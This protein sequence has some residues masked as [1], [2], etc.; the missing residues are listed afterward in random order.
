M[1]VRHP[2]VRRALEN[3]G[4][5]YLYLYSYDP[6]W[7]RHVDEFDQLVG[8]VDRACRDE[9]VPPDARERIVARMV[10]RV[11]PDARTWEERAREVVAIANFPLDPRALPDELRGLLPDADHPHRP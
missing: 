5:G 6:A 1:S 10:E 4:E 11:L 3:G 2:A 7:R 9:G 8:V